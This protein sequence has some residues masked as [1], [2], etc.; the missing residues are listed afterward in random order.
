MPT[1]D[2]S[3]AA[4]AFLDKWA[5]PASGRYLQM[6]DGL[7]ALL[8]TVRAEAAPRW[9]ACAEGLPALAKRVLIWFRGAVEPV[10]AHWNGE[11]GV[12]SG[13]RWYNPQRVTHWRPLP[14]GPE[15]GEKEC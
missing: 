1:N 2:L 3:P 7:A 11:T 9:T 10:E 12:S 14:P 8:E 5:A 4:E 13:Q 6:R 15:E